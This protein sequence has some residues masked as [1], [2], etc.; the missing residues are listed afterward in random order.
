MCCCGGRDQRNRT[1][2]RL[3]EPRMVD[4]P[5]AMSRRVVLVLERRDDFHPGPV[6]VRAENNLIALAIG[7]KLGPGF[8]QDLAAIGFDQT[9]EA[10]RIMT[11][12]A[13]W[14]RPSWADTPLLG[15]AL[16]CGLVK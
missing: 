15:F 8:L 11:R 2:H 4:Q 1:S 7:A 5:M 3:A 9:D 13:K 12:K 14:V 6:R 16:T 10:V